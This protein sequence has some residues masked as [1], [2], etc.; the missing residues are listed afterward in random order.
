MKEIQIFKITS[1]CNALKSQLKFLLFENEEYMFKSINERII[2]VPVDTQNKASNVQFE[3]EF[4][5]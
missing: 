5:T 2:K 4:Q 3:N 1:K